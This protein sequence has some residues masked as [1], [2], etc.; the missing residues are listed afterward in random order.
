MD[1]VFFTL[2]LRIGCNGS[3][4]LFLHIFFGG[5]FINNNI[6]DINKAFVR[7]AHS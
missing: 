7:K 1:E 2:Y 4:N 6:E 3:F 5:L